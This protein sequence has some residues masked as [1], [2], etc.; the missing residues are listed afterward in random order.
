MSWINLE[1]AFKINRAIFVI[2]LKEI[3]IGEFQLLEGA[4]RECYGSILNGVIKSMV[5]TY[6]PDLTGAVISGITYDLMRN[7]LHIQV[8]HSSLPEVEDGNSAKCF[9]LNPDK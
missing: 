7:I 3:T 9:W 1:H 8:V 4:T 2:G 5:M 6:R